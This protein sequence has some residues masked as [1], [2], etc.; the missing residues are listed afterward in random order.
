MKSTKLSLKGFELIKKFEGISLKPYLCPAGIP[1]ISIGC[2]YYPDGTKVKMT[3]SE[4]SQAKATEIFLNVIKHFENSVD[5]FTRDDISQNQFDSLVSFSY[6]LG[7]NALKNSTLLKKVNLNP[8]DV[9]I[10]DEFLRWNK[11]N[12]K[13]LKGLTTRRQAEADL[14]FS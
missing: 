5:S 8:K 1:T 2:T 12:G 6:N 3:D 13:V 7:A 4:I 10:A 9:S 14:Y 11:S